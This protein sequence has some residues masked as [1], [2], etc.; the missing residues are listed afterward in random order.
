MVGGHIH[1]LCNMPSITKVSSAILRS[2]Q[3]GINSHLRAL[4]ALKLPVDRW[5]TIIIHLMVEKLDVESHRLWESS[6]SSASLPLIQEYLSFLNQQ[7]NP[8]LH[9]EYV[10][11]MR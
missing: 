1:A 8:K 3:N 11:F 7:C 2:H 6:R 9:K 4:T 10:H 5:D